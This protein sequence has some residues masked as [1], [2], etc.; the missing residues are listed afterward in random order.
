MTHISRRNKLDS[1]QR[2]GPSMIAL[3]EQKM[4]TY[5]NTWYVPSAGYLRLHDIVTI[6]DVFSWIFGVLHVYGVQ[7]RI[8]A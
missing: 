7:L 1:D 2:C 5:G 3:H 8:I 6:P 4:T